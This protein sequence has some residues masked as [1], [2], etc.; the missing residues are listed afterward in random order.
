MLRSLSDSR[1]PNKVCQADAYTASMPMQHDCLTIEAC[2][3]LICLPGHS[4]IP[5]LELAPQKRRLCQYCFCA[6][7][8]LEHIA[9]TDT[10]SI[11]TH[12]IH[13]SL[14]RHL[15][16]WHRR[17]T[18]LAAHTG[19]KSKISIKRGRYVCSTL[20]RRLSG[21][22]LSGFDTAHRDRVLGSRPC[23]LRARAIFSAATVS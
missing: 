12:P 21:G 13:R 1:V 2:R 22:S 20:R 4:L 18:L 10:L 5:G 3:I 7:I 8:Y 9:P 19:C 14:T 16:D 6:S 17:G 15:Q 23:S 11:C